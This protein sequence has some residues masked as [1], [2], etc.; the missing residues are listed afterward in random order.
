MKH[1]TQHKTKVCK[2]ANYTLDIT[3]EKYV[4]VIPIHCGITAEKY[5]NVIPI[6]CGITAEKT[7]RALDVEPAAMFL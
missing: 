7:K 3:V 4:N 1:L 5:A 2:L 6:H